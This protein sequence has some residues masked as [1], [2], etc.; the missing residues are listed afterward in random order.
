MHPSLPARTALIAGL[1]LAASAVHAQSRPQSHV[2]PVWDKK[3]G[4]VEALLVLEPLDSRTRKPFSKAAL[5]ASFG[6]SAGDQLGLVCGPR[7]TT[8]SIGG[9]VGNCLV[10]AVDVDG[11]TSR[12]GAVGATAGRNGTR[13]GVGFTQRDQ[14][15]P[16]WLSAGTPQARVSTNAL[17]LVGERNVGREATVSIGGTL[18][19][20]RL[21]SPSTATALQ[22]RWDMQALSIGARFGRFS[23]NVVGRVVDS[24]AD[25]R[26]GGVDLGFSWRTPWSG[27]LSIG[28]ENV[29]TRGRNPFSRSSAEE[30]QA[31]VPYVR[32]QQ[33]L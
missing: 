22:D 23:A 33:D 5:D 12:N 28:A 24:A 14:S 11:R 17:T 13:L 3:S 26:W 25:Q 18:A 10:A 4:Q 32:Y 27:Q 30:D 6:V 7:S 15:L 2:L 8:G 19:R 9:L 31:A 1:L 29:V 21:V 20:A 16:A